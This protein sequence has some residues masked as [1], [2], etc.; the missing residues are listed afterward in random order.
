LKPHDALAKV[1]RSINPG[2]TSIGFGAVINGR[3]VGMVDFEL[4]PSAM[5]AGGTMLSG[6]SRSL[7]GVSV[8][9]TFAP[10]RGGFRVGMRLSASLP[11]RCARLDGLVIDFAPG[12]SL[13][14]WRVPTMGAG[15]ESVGMVPVHRL[16]EVLG[17]DPIQGTAGEPKFAS[18][19]RFRGVFP[20]S[21]HAGLFLGTVLPQRHTHIYTA[22]RIGTEALRFTASTIF[23]EG[24]SSGITFEGE[25]TWVCGSLPVRES[26]KA[27]VEHLPEL[28]HRKPAVGWNSWDYYFFTAGMDDI[29]ENMDVISADPSLARALRYIVVDEC[30]EHMNGEWQANYKFPG[31]TA[32]MAREILGRG[33]LPGIWTAPLLVNVFSHVALRQSDMLI[34]N[35]HGDPAGS[36]V[37]CHY[38]LDPTHPLAQDF[39]RGL[40]TRLYQEGFRFFKLDFFASLLL[41]KRLHDLSKGSHEALADLFR[42]VRECVGPDSH[43]LGG[44][45]PGGTVDSHRTGVDVHNQWTHVQWTTEFLQ[46]TWWANRRLSTVDPDF[47]VVRGRDTS[48]EAETNVLNPMAHNPDPPRWR[49]GPVFTLEEARTWATIVSLSGGNVFLSDRL[50]MLNEA[51]FALVRRVLE[52]TGVSAE[53]LDLGDGDQPSLWYADLA[54]ERRLAI[55][56][57]TALPTVRA[58]DFAAHA[59]AAPPSV[60]DFWSDASLPTTDG[61]LTVRL[62]AHASAYVRW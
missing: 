17:P 9:W 58:F 33:F 2:L 40:Y 61:R 21:H 57:W 49:R 35:E 36:D 4:S 23:I 27:Y 15:V 20:N 48:R 14:N 26:F 11:I 12:G 24:P 39:L 5:P 3:S 55:I 56:N 38:L 54:T 51:G 22:E 41:T 18:G 47:L 13:D 42:L 32:G 8:Q 10:E 29:K 34:K 53:P 25:S 46:L 45:V 44:P 31:G 1:A 62:S 7:K 52:P 16:S 30:W 43:I 28:P 60:T 37:G 50:S 19:A 6:P 59:I